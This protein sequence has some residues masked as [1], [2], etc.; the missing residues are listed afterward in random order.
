[1]LVFITE[2]DR[3]RRFL[4]A[5]RFYLE[6]EESPPGAE[7]PGTPNTRLISLSPSFNPQ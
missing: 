7:Q 5:Q 6:K 1:M 2:E 3:T 4:C